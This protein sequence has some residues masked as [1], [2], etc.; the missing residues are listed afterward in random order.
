M[1]SEKPKMIRNT[2][3]TMISVL[4][5]VK[6][7]F[8]CGDTYIQSRRIHVLGSTIQCRENVQDLDLPL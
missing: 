5:L 8:S 2:Y 4:Y 6:A 3:F 7:N 1:Y